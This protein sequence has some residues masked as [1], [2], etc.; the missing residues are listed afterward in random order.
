MSVDP[1]QGGN[2]PNKDEVESGDVSHERGEA[3]SGAGGGTVSIETEAARRKISDELS[4]NLGSAEPIERNS[5]EEGSFR[6]DSSIQ[7][8]EGGRDCEESVGERALRLD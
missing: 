8:V 2:R 5:Q 1:S 4:E 6:F 7:V 3:R